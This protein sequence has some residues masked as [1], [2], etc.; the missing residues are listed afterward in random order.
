MSC[1]SKDECHCPA[2]IDSAC[3]E[4]VYDPKERSIL[5]NEV[6]HVAPIPQA[7][8]AIIRSILALAGERIAA[9]QGL[10]IETAMQRLSR[11]VQGN[12]VCDVENDS[13]LKA[14]N[15]AHQAWTATH[16]S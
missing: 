5:L 14:A 2:C 12:I 11:A 9:K 13:L 6:I 7:S 4:Q 1:G 3:D 15:A 10:V 8:Q 16:A